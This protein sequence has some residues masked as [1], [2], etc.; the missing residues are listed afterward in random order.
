MGVGYVFH[1][2]NPGE[3]GNDSPRSPAR[4]ITVVSPA[5]GTPVVVTVPQ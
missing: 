1:I 3:K 4:G 5:D 2:Y